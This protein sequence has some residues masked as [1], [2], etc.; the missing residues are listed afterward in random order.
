[1][2]AG[3]SCLQILWIITA[4]I[5]ADPE[6]QTEESLGKECGLIGFVISTKAYDEGVKLTL[7]VIY[8]LFM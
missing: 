2:T 4:A 5:S 8:S 1:M 7:F 3:R 6:S